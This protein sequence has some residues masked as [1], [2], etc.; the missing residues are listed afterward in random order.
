MLIISALLISLTY[1]VIKKNI[2]LEKDKA[3]LIIEIDVKSEAQT[4]LLNIEGE[5]VIVVNEYEKD[6][7]A[8]KTSKDS[9]EQ[10]LYHEIEKLELKEKEVNSLKYIYNQASNVIA[11][12]IIQDTIYKDSI[13]R[14]K[15]SIDFNDGFLHAVLSNDTMLKYQY[16]EE[17]YMLNV[18]RK[19]NR[20]FFVWRWIGW[21]KILDKNK[22]EVRSS[23]PNAE[24]KIL[25]SIKTQ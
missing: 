1:K 22:F 21:K 2:A 6:M 20:K 15:T 9:I 16:S 18:K 25:R 14:I 24:I 4:K 23:N 5:L 8:L 7:E 13:V 12:I 19:V 17:L 11:G 10:K 3:N